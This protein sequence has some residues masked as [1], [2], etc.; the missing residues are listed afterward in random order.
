[1]PTSIDPIPRAKGLRNV[2]RDRRAECSAPKSVWSKL[3]DY[4]GELDRLVPYQ[5]GI[6][7]NVPHFRRHDVGLCRKVSP[8]NI[9]RYVLAPTLPPTSCLGHLSPTAP[10]L[11][12]K[13]H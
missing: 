12:A 4:I 11:P 7:Q 10:P 13:R 1:M 2:A 8:D 3:V 5:C 6:V 9:D